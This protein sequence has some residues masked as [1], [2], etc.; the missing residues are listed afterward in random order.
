MVVYKLSYHHS[1][2]VKLYLDVKTLLEMLD[3]L[4]VIRIVKH[5]Y[6]YLQQR[7]MIWQDLLA[8]EIVI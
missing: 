5:C 6:Q 2:R 7:M 8:R 4:M 3:L 1:Q